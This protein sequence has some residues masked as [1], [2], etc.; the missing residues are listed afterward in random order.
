MLVDV[1]DD[2]LCLCFEE[3]IDG[4][5]DPAKVSCSID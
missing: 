1:S 3:T 5:M 4:L 2:G